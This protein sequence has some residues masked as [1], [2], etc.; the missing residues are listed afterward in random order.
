VA[1]ILFAK[2]HRSPEVVEHLIRSHHDCVI[3]LQLDRLA[4]LLELAGTVLP[5]DSPHTRAVIQYFLDLNVPIVQRLMQLF[6]SPK[7]ESLWLDDVVRTFR[8]TPRFS[9]SDMVH[10]EIIGKHYRILARF[11]LLR[12]DETNPVLSASPRLVSVSASDLVAFLYRGLPLTE[13]VLSVLLPVPREEFAM[14]QPFLQPHTRVNG[15]PVL[16][17]AAARAL[18]DMVEQLLGTGADPNATDT[19]GR[20]ALHAMATGRYFHS[21]LVV[22][23]QRVVQLLVAA[24]ADVNRADSAG[25]TPLHVLVAPH[26][27][28]CELPSVLVSMLLDAGAD[29][30]ALNREHSAPFGDEADARVRLYRPPLG[31][32]PPPSPGPPA[33]PVV[34]RA[35]LPLLYGAPLSSELVVLGRVRISAESCEAL[36]SPHECCVYVGPRLYFARQ[37]RHHH[38]LVG[39]RP[40]GCALER[41]CGYTRRATRC[42]V[43]ATAAV[44]GGR[45]VCGATDVHRAV[46][47]AVHSR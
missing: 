17:L 31:A 15:V 41:V 27:W 20:T 33:L 25:C 44:G 1:A 4:I 14:V 39:R 12:P 10:G 36:G 29:P 24:G 6:G 9:L 47:A 18:V 11:Q 37:K 28:L 2:R 32:P 3:K 19:L 13:P 34:R 35:A 16:H 30:S 26:K 45:T 46:D 8:P 43:D 22:D 23:W 42:V 21:R 7:F 40:R 5:A 38:G